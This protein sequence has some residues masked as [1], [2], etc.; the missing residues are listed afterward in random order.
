LNLVG[1]VR[2]RLS[3]MDEDFEV[4]FKGR[5][6]IG[7][8][9]GPRMKTISPMCHEEEWIAYVRVV[10]KSKIHGI[11]LVLRMVGRNNVGDENSRSMMVLKTT[12]NVTLCLHN[13][14]KNL[15]MT[16]MQM[17]PLCQQ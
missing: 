5:I 8:S 14:Q 17:S 15:M 1:L 2:E 11:E 9:N 16:L 10:M 7:S 6:D 3:W 13:Y 4:R 12:L